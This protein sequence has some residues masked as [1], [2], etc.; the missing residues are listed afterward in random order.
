MAIMNVMSIMAAMPLM[1]IIALMATMTNY[2]C[3]CDSLNNYESCYIGDMDMVKMAAAAITDIMATLTQYIVVM[4]KHSL[5]ALIA[6]MSF[7]TP[8]TV[9]AVQ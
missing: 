7:M 6:A 3:Q 2:H 9:I 4:T 5:T 1:T 8:I